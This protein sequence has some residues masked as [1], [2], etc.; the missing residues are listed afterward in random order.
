MVGAVGS[1]DA[2]GAAELGDDR[3]HRFAPGIPHPAFDRGNGAVERTEQRGKAPIRS[4]FVGVGVP[5]V[6]RERADAG[7][8]GPREELGGGAGRFKK[9][10]AHRASAGQAPARRHVAVPGDG[11]NAD[12][13]LE[14]ARQL[15]VGVRIQIEQ[16]HHR[17]V[18]GRRQARRR[19]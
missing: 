3:D 6:E 16:S 2:R 11:R 8:V 5:A 13:F 17:V 10:A 4:A 19:P 7:T 14:R 9:I 1:V 18:A 15:R 12:A